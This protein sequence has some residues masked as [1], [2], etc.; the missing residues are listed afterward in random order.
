[1]S[2]SLFLLPVCRWNVSFHS[3]SWCLTYQYGI[4]HFGTRSQ[5][6]TSLPK[7]V[8]GH[9]I[10]FLFFFLILFLWLSYYLI[11][12]C[13]LLNSYSLFGCNFCS[14]Y[15]DIYMYILKGN[16]LSPFM[17]VRN[18]PLV[19]DSHL[20]CTS[21]EKTLPLLVSLCCL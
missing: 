21:L 8:S 16:L 19:L 13:C 15:L 5:N 3:C 4:Y 18:W 1:M 7:L 20:V 10:F 11:S 12:P 2:W 17:Y 6:K 9:G 14:T